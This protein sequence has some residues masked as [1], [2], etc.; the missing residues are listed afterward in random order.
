MKKQII[1]QQGIDGGQHT[2]GGNVLESVAYRLLE[3]PDALSDTHEVSI[4]FNYIKT[5]LF[6][7]VNIGTNVKSAMVDKAAFTLA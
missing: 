6:L 2:Q 4:S 7:C 5:C 3:V 1:C